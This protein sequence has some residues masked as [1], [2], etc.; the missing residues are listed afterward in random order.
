MRTKIAR[1]IAAIAA[2]L[3]VAGM[4][5]TARAADFSNVVVSSAE[6]G[7]NQTAFPRETPEIFIRANMVDMVPGSVVTITWL[8]VDTGPENPPNFRLNQVSLPVGKV[9]R[10]L[11]TS[12]ARPGDRWRPGSY[13]V[14]LSLDRQTLERID[15]TIE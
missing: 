2:L 1:L 13:R 12:I 11:R 3:T 5:H 6:D 15:F 8:A 9:G 14:R 7:E 10:L 4:I